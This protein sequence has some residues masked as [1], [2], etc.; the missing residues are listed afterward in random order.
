MA[1]DDAYEALRRFAREKFTELRDL[2]A[3]LPSPPPDPR[4][5]KIDA[6][7]QEIARL[8]VIVTRVIYIPREP[9]DPGRGEAYVQGWRDARALVDKALLP[10]DE[11]QGS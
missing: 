9:A 3:A 4:D 11:G 2:L 8:R 10:E 7:R 6:Q 1:S 5:E